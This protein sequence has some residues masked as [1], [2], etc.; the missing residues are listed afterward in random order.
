MMLA[1][2]DDVHGPIGVVRNPG[3][4]VDS[5]NMKHDVDA[6]RR[7]RE[8][9]PIP[10]VARHQL[11]AGG[12]ERVGAAGV[13]HERAHGVTAPDQLVRKMSAGETGRSGD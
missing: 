8:R 6:T 7:R 13:A 9:G 10:Q 11:D 1:D 3:L 4:P 5:R 2:G 12:T